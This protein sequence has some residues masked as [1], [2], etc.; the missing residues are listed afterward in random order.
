MRRDA[1]IPLGRFGLPFEVASVA[2][3]LAMNNCELNLDGQPFGGGVP[4]QF[5]KPARL[6]RGVGF[7]TE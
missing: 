4:Q 2:M 6:Y 5:P 1:R 3:F 7:T